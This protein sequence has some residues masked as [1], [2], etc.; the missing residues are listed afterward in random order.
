MNENHDQRP[1]YRCS[2]R[3]CGLVQYPAANGRCRKCGTPFGATPAVLPS[4]ALAPRREP[5]PAHL[6]S[7]N[8]GRAIRSLRRRAGLSQLRLAQ[9]AG[10]C[11][12]RLSMIESGQRV[13]S[14]TT[15][16]SMAAELR[17]DLADILIMI[18]RQADSHQKE[19]AKPPQSVLT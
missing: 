18:R 19:E 6:Y 13:P 3:E 1:V 5:L 4:S 16:E 7:A 14:I 17:I 15:V 8:I 2:R 9:A 10:V 11:R 12:S